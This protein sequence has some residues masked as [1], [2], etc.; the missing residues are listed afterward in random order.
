MFRIT[1]LLVREQRAKVKW[2]KPFFRVFFRHWIKD[3]RIKFFEKY[4]EKYQ[5]NYTG[6]LKKCFFFRIITSC[7]NHFASNFFWTTLLSERIQ[8]IDDRKVNNI[9]WRKRFFYW[10]LFSLKRFAC[11]CIIHQWGYIRIKIK[12]IIIRKN[13]FCSVS[14]FTKKLWHCYEWD[15]RV[16]KI[17]KILFWGTFFSQKTFLVKKPFENFFIKDQ[18]AQKNDESNWN[19]YFEKK[20][21]GKLLWWEIFVDVIVVTGSTEARP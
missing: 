16:L 21:F 19:L 17:K 14:F 5:W 20:F 8:R 9:M 2:T 18:R 10:S 3:L 4:G 1:L 6:T 7:E 12:R 15:Y 11:F 13:C